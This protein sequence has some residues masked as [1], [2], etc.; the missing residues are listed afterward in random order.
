M[1]E[2]EKR[3]EDLKLIYSSDMKK[4][5]ESTSDFLLDLIVDLQ[6]KVE[7]LEREAL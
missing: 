2:K 1:D 7:D 6:L 3:I 5:N 4:Y